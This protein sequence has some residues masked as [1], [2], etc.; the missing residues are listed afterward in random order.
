MINKTILKSNPPQRDE[1]FAFP[2]KLV[3]GAGDDNNSLAEMMREWLNRYR[4][5]EADAV[6]MTMT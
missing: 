3:A 2:V 6:W 4:I 1:V 5:T